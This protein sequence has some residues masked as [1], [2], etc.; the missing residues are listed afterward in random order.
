MPTHPQTEK[1]ELSIYVY[2]VPSFQMNVGEVVPVWRLPFL[3]LA[4]LSSTF[5]LSLSL[6]FHLR[7]YCYDRP[8]N[9]NIIKEEGD[10]KRKEREERATIVSELYRYWRLS[11]PQTHIWGKAAVVVIISRF[12]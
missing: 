1:G 10:L 7:S 3:C 6:S 5:S 2:R 4:S 12:P 11:V 9:E 8:R